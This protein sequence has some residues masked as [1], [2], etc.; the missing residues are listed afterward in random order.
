M[1]DVC[2]AC[3]TS[4]GPSKSTTISSPLRGNDKAGVI[5]RKARK[6]SVQTMRFALCDFRRMPCAVNILPTAY[7]L[8]LTVHCWD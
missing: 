7:C 6:P 3:L 2:H 5:S 1:F 4:E 8:I